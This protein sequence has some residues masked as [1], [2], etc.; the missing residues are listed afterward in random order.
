MVSIIQIQCMPQI[1][2]NQPV[3][4]DLNLNNLLRDGGSHEPNLHYGPPTASPTEP[5]TTSAEDSNNCFF[6]YTLP[7]AVPTVPSIFTSIIDCIIE[8]LK[9]VGNWCSSIF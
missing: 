2:E 9:I 6:C 7:A 4:F 1:Q 3:L 5:P 8:N